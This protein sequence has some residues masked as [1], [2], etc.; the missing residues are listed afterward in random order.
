MKKEQ[1]FLKTKVV[2]LRDRLV[3]R[4]G[5]AEKCKL[6]EAMG[7]VKEGVV[8]SAPDMVEE[9]SEEEELWDEDGLGAKARAVAEVTD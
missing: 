8:P 3:V 9:T 2:L 6:Q 5:K 4:E 1:K 7:E